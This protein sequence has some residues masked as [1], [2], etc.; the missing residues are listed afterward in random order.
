MKRMD[1]KEGI[2]ALRKSGFSTLEIKRLFRL[3]RTYTEH[4]MD[5][6]PA[7]RSHLQFVRWLVM[8]GRLSE[9]IND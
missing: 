6:A 8:N 5:E 3:R 9:Q 2:E 7:F 4:E 1:Q